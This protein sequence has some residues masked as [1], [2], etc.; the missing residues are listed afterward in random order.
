LAVFQAI[1]AEAL[2]ALPRV[3]FEL[4]AWS[5]P[6]VGPDCHVKVGPALYSVPFRLIGQHVDARATDRSVE[7]FLD[8]VLVKTWGRAKGG[9]RTDYADY[10]PEKV[11]FFMRTPAW[12]RRRADQLGPAVA[13]LVGLL[14]ADPVLHRLRSAQGVLRLADRYP[15][16]RLDAACARAITVGDPGYRTVKGIL[17]AGTEHDGQPTSAVVDAP[18]HLHGPATLFEHLTD[19]RE[20]AG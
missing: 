17:L 12:C 4:A 18:A 10:P 16:A 19:G 15:A 11:A 13:E 14:L 1:E 9:R 6:K 3:A 7:I 5:R 2:L 20:V 8:G